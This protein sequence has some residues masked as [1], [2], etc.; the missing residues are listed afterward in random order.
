MR[1]FSKCRILI[2]QTFEYSR[3]INMPGF[4]IYR[5]TQGLFI[6][7]NMTAFLICVRMQFWKGSEYSRIPNIPGLCICKR[8]ARFWGVNISTGH[9]TMSGKNSNYVRRNLLQYRDSCPVWSYRR[10]QT[11]KHS[12]SKDF[13]CSSFS[14]YERFN[15]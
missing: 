13:S 14:F 4:R 10:L 5:V 8:Y 11:Q 9:Y 2:C 12:V 7:I 3:I 15:K 6:F 1:R